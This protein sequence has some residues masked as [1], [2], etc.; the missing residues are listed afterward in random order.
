[1]QIKLAGV[2]L[3][4]CEC[5]EIAKSHP[6]KTGI[7]TVVWQRYCLIPSPLELQLATRASALTMQSKA[8]TD[9]EILPENQNCVYGCGHQA[10]FADF[11]TPRFCDCINVTFQACRLYPLC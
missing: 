9:E 4:V 10:G 8:Y 3:N 1:M 6:E 7:M 5:D 11:S 2:G